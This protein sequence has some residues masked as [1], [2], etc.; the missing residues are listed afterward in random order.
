[1]ARALRHVACVAT[2]SM[3]VPALALAADGYDLLATTLSLTPDVAARSIAA[4]Q[5]T[6]L[7]AEADLTEVRFDANALTVVEATLGGEP[8]VRRSEE[9]ATVFVLPRTVREGEVVELRFEYRGAPAR[10]LVFDDGILYT[11][12]FSCDWMLCALDRPGD[13]FTAELAVAAPEG[14]TSFTS[15]SAR[16]Y[17][18][19]SRRGGAGSR[20]VRRAR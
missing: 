2:A 5:T 3:L 20:R 15:E 7:R 19:A 14:W 10:G 17:P 1:V 4:V 13:K 18:A 12:Y 11:S 8:L 9:R 16:A 6:A